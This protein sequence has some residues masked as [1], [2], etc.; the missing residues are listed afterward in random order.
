M[1]FEHNNPVPDSST[2]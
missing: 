2:S 1:K